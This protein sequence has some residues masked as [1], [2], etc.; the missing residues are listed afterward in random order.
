MVIVQHHQLNNKKP[1]SFTEFG[2]PADS[3]EEEGGK[4]ITMKVTEKEKPMS[5]VIKRVANKGA[6][7]SSLPSVSSVF[8]SSLFPL[9]RMRKS[10]RVFKICADL[11]AG[12]IHLNRLLRHLLGDVLQFDHC[13]L[14]RA[15]LLVYVVR[16]LLHLAGDVL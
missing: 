5:L 2:C 3:L 7:F 8:N 9:M 11:C 4:E 16:P 6:L 1:Q 14:N 15:A 13:L 10:F 12:G